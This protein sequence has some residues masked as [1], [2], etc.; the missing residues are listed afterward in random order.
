MI[1]KALARLE[2]GTY[3]ICTACGSAISP[4]RLEVMPAAAL[5][6]GCAR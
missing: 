1:T 4:K 2:V 5:C 6:I 3:G